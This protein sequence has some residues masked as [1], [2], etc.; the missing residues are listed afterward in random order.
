[1]LKPRCLA[2]KVEIPSPKGT[3]EKNETQR[4]R[5]KRGGKGDRSG[6]KGTGIR[7]MKEEGEKKTSG[8]CE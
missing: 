7:W 4:G 3:G 8:E 5:A 6:K 2:K 1:M